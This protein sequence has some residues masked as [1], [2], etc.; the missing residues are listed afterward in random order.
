LAVGLLLSPT[1]PSSSL[2]RPWPLST[3]PEA[4]PSETGVGS[5]W[6]SELASCSAHSPQAEA[7]GQESEP[8]C[9]E[10]EHIKPRERQRAARACP[11]PATDRALDSSAF[12]ETRA[13]LLR[14]RQGRPDENSQDDCRKCS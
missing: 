12:A 14:E 7:D 3:N 10:N 11:A 8:S 9:E 13:R 1:L 4:S 5:Y 6:A 2:N